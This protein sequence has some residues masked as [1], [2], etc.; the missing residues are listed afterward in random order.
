MLLACV[1]CTADGLSVPYDQ[2]YV[3]CETNADCPREAPLCHLH[4]VRD[5]ATDGAIVEVRQCTRR[6]TAGTRSCAGF[7]IYL[8]EGEPAR[9]L[10]AR[11]VG[12]DE[13]DVYDFS[14]VGLEF[15]YPE[16]YCFDLGIE[17][18]VQSRLE[19]MGLFYPDCPTL[20]TEPRRIVS[21]DQGTLHRVCLPG[22]V[23][24]AEDATP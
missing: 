20:G 14:A 2:I 23:M 13:D 22:G 6:C 4:R 8:F 3:A 11:C 9:I 18:S 1:G 10:G 12:V 19:S 7:D 5:A 17:P 21:D 24:P 16:G 15:R